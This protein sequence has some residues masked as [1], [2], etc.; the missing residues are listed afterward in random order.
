VQ[1]PECAQFGLLSGPHGP[2]SLLVYGG[3]PIR[4]FVT[5][6]SNQRSSSLSDTL[7]GLLVVDKTGLPDTNC[8]TEIPPAGTPCAPLFHILV[9]YATDE[10]YLTFLE[11][12]VGI[13][14]DRTVPKAP[15]IFD[16]LEKLGLHLAKSKVSREFI[17]IDK[18]ERPSPN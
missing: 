4:T 14:V 3:S 15:N 13:T 7:K 10:S 2:N 11:T 17:V 1:P 9:E 6:L 18:I 16:A 8:L 5:V 12:R